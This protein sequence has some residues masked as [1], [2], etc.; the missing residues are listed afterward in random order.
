MDKDQI[1]DKTM[2]I[3]E[4]VSKLKH[5]SRLYGINSIF[6]AGGYCRSLY[7]NRLW[8]TNDIDVASAYEHQATELGG[9]FASEVVNVMPSFYKRTGT[10]MIEYSSG[11]GKIKIEFQGR[12]TQDYMYNEEVRN[13]LHQHDIEDIPLLHNI[14]GRDFTI[15]SLIFSLHS[16][17]LYDLTDMGV[18]DFERKQIVSL[19]PAEM[20]MK[21]NPIVALRA[22]RFVLLYDFT[23][24]NDLE[25][26]IPKSVDQLT[27][28]VSM[29]RIL[30]EIIKILK[31]DGR[32]S[33]KLMKRY[34]LHRLLLNEKL[35]DL[36]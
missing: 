12:S 8:E 21:F 27:T 5:F 23:I 25:E 22:I 9:L 30:Q 33:I 2:L 24:A 3:E 32:K 28:S 18:R 7:L 20:I 34:G 35:K 31:I 10:A 6:I 4:A 36:F 19:L 13:W 29:D 1:I 26:L 16:E 14:Y 15:N 11:S 17:N